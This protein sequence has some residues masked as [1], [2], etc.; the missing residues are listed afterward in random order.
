MGFSDEN[1]TKDPETLK[2]ILG[3]FGVSALCFL[4]PGL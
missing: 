1:L 4:Y 2:I 3:P